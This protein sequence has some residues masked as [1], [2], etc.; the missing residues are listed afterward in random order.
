MNKAIIYFNGELIKSVDYDVCEPDDNRNVYV[1]SKNIKDS[2]S[3]LVVALVP[4][5]YMIE[6][7]S[8]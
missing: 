1:L 2:K 3:T 7:I 8:K 5:N 6:F 4:F